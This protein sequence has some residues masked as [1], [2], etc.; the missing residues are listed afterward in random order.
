MHEVE[1]DN[2]ANTCDVVQSQPVRVGTLGWPS[3]IRPS[4]FIVFCFRFFICL[5]LRVRAMTSGG[6]V[7]V[8]GL[9]GLGVT[10][11]KVT[12]IQLQ[13]KFYETVIVTETSTDDW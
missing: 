2:E 13:S 11:T 10:Q 5:W 12:E 8:C 4:L 6:N 9:L 7:G 3:E 1:A